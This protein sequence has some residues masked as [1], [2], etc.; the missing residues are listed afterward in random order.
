MPTT[1]IARMGWGTASQSAAVIVA[2]RRWS[3][4]RSPS[5]STR[6]SRPAAR[7]SAGSRSQS[8]K[9]IRRQTVGSETSCQR[10]IVIDTCRHDTVVETTTGRVSKSAAKTST[11]GTGG[12]GTCSTN[13]HVSTAIDPAVADRARTTTSSSLRS[14]TR[15][16]AR[17]RAGASARSAATMVERVAILQLYGVRSRGPP[18]RFAAGRS[19]SFELCADD[20][21]HG[22][23]GP[24]V[25]AAADACTAASPRT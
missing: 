10:G 11:E 15:R 18:P 2:H 14:P 17:R 6:R 8:R 24:R 20:W 3:T 13:C 4:M 12:S 16:R 5:R 23:L 19:Q 1:A 22:V 7:R 21:E 25:R 9:N